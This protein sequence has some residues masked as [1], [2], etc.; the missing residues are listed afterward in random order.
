LWSL[1][2]RELTADQAGDLSAERQQVLYNH[3]VR[4]HKGE[5]ADAALRHRAATEEVGKH[6]E[7]LD[8]FRG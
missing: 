1:R 6:G 4:T 2:G 7:D 8:T 5:V 3:W